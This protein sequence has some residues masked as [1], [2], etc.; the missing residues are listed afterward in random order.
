VI[1]SIS[2]SAI[3]NKLTRS[4]DRLKCSQ[5]GSILASPW[6]RRKRGQRTRSGPQRSGA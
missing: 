2:H 5:I 3:Y 4:F 1:E 6:T